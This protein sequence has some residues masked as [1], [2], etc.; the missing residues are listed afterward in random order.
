MS[1]VAARA[2]AEARAGRMV[3]YREMLHFARDPARTVMSL[4][5]PLLFLCILGVGLSG[6]VPGDGYAGFL[7]PGVLVMAAQTPAI[8]VGVSIVWDRQIGFLREMLVA[9]VARSTLVAGKCLGGATMATCTGGIVL[10]FAGVAGLPYDPLLFALLL[11]ELALAA[12]TMTA[13]ASLVAVAVRRAQTCNTVLGVLVTPMVFLSGMMFPVSAMPPWM[14]AAAM[15]NPL[16]YVLDAMRR[17]IA[18][19]SPEHAASSLFAPLTL[20]ARQLP[21]ALEM[22]LV[23]GFAL[24]ALAAAGACFSRR[25]G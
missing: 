8:S 16:T 2:A 21:V 13:L 23:A 6:L 7:F 19:A 9:P 25:D 22:L 1:A 18:A 14:A 20:G 10:V 15:A 4:F 11:A 17:T 3:W 5:H 24:A 12:L